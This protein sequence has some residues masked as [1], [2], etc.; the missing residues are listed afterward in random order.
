M[1]VIP[2][3]AIFDEEKELTKSE[4]EK[5]EA[6]S[7]LTIENDENF[8]N[9]IT[10][11]TLPEAYQEESERISQYIT[12][13]N[14]ILY[15]MINMADDLYQ[16][17]FPKVDIQSIMNKTNVVNGREQKKIEDFLDEKAIETKA[18]GRGE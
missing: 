15:E 8:S 3:F 4:L 16:G 18:F 14:E 10:N 1:L 5:F 6:I 9:Y 12:M 17:I 11:N 7:K 2:F 13:S